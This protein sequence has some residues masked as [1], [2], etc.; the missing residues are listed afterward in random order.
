M[1]GATLALR[2]RL[3]ALGEG[4]LTWASGPSDAVLHF[5]RGRRSEAELD[6]SE[7]PGFACLVNLS[8]A[9]VTLREGTEVLL[10]SVPSAGRELPVDAA[11][12]LAVRA[13]PVRTT[14]SGVATSSSE[15]RSASTPST[16]A[17]TPPT[18]MTP[19]PSR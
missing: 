11:V 5:R 2:R 1:A 14:E 18:I 7:Q 3:P 17:T 8:D 13:H 6:H 19:A 12:W 4:D 10:S 15:R 16:A 9:P